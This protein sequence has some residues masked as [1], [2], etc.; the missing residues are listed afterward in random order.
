MTSRAR[1]PAEFGA[2]LISLALTAAFAIALL[3]VKAAPPA[4]IHALVTQVQL[5]V[6]APPKPEP[7]PQPKVQKRAP[8][9]TRR[10]HVL[11]RP[12]PVRRIAHVEAAPQPVEEPEVAAPPAEPAAAAAPAVGRPDP[13]LAYEAALKENIVARTCGPNTPEYRLLHPTGT[14]RVN[15]VIDR[16]GA[17]SNVRIAASSGSTILDRQAD[18]IVSQGRYPRMPA[19]V[20]AGETSHLFLVEIEFRSGGGCAS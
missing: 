18:A 20:F 16:I 15:F 4:G 14:S 12:M 7:A 11:A 2:Q 8:A 6:I 1:D 9:P 17:V 19:D 13:N 3:A 10:T 5:S